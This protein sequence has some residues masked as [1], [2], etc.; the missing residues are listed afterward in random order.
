LTRSL[1]L[2]DRVPWLYIIASLKH[3]VLYVGETFDEAGISGRLSSHFGRALSSNFKR[4]VAEHA[5][6][7]N[8]SGPYLVLAA[9]LPFGDND[10]LFNGESKKVRKAC[11][12][13]LH[14]ILTSSFILPN[15]WTIVSSATSSLKITD[16]MTRSCEEISECF[17][18]S[19]RFFQNL[20]SDVLPFNL[21]LL[22]KV[23]SDIDEKTPN[24]GEV[25]EDIE[26]Q[27][28]DWILTMLKSEFG[29]KWWTEGIKKTIRQNCASKQEDEGVSD[30]VPKEA[31][32]TLIDIRAII[33]CNWNLF[34]SVMEE[35]SGLNG[36]AK[37]TSWINDINEKRKLWAHPLKQR[38]VTI[39]PSAIKM[40]SSYQTKLRVAIGNDS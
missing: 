35:V 22:D 34:S 12:S 13:I 30:S 28:F 9:R 24:I 2:T 40:V 36:K 16:D 15:N 6:V 18:S 20:S 33:E 1:T 10:A 27:L 25:I 37:S 21:V 31:Y 8:V 23:E 11:E 38:F 39:E 4:C 17:L 14:E 32:M 26:L 5:G 7:R 19:F 3:K 29:D